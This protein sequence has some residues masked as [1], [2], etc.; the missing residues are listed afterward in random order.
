MPPRHSTL[1]QPRR[2]PHSARDLILKAATEAFIAHGFSG[3]SIDDIAARAGV[4]KPTIYSHF[5]GKENLFVA[6]LSGVCDSFVGPILEPGADSEELASILVKIA[7][8]YT[9]SVLQRN[10][11]ALHRLFVAE[12][13]RFPDLS[14]RYYQAGP[15]RVHRALADFLKTRMARGELRADDPLVLA[16]FFAALVLAPL[17]ARQLF[18]VD[19]DI[20]WAEADRYSRKA[21]ALFLDGCRGGAGRAAD[22]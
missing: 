12:A 16:E 1:R 6:I 8:S 22:R 18:A 15:E 3:A 9:R 14:R 17:R 11:V 7:D 13:E 21:V 20:D 19:A 5:D 4:S 10:I 2:P